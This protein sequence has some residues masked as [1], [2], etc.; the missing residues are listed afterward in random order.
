MDLEQQLLL[1]VKGES[2]D[3]CGILPYKDGCKTETFAKW[4]KII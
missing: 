4:K 2:C 3:V 1:P